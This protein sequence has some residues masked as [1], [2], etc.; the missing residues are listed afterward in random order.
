MR[1]FF[2]KLFW[3]KIYKLDGF[4]LN[5]NFFS[6]TPQYWKAPFTVMQKVLRNGSFTLPDT[7]TATDT[8][9]ICTEPKEICIGLS[10]G[11]VWTL[12]NIIIEPNCIGLCLC[13][14]L[15]LGLVQCKNTVRQEAKSCTWGPLIFF[16][17]H[18]LFQ[19]NCHF[20]RFSKLMGILFLFLKRSQYDFVTYRWIYHDCNTH[21]IKCLHSLSNTIYNL[22]LHPG[23]RLEQY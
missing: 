23:E 16:R 15:A 8:D 13:L 11:S 12:R 5:K 7:D 9:K 21:R 3:I 19:V 22:W 17:F 4:H 20:S 6:T 10:L 18:T 1:C 14:G 2:K